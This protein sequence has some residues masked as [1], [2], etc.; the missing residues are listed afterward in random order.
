L[1]ANE[2]SETAPVNKAEGQPNEAD[3][4]S[5]PAQVHAPMSENSDTE[6]APEAL[7][8]EPVV[9]DMQTIAGGANSEPREAA[10]AVVAVTSHYPPDYSPSSAAVSAPPPVVE[11]VQEPAPE[12]APEAPRPELQFADGIVEV[13]G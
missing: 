6:A 8:G 9:P 3:A 10:A 7:T 12:P 1:P 4:S 11:R 5:A 13:S 2:Q